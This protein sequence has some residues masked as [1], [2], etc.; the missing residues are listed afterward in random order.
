MRLALD[1]MG[2]DHAPKAMVEGGFDY[3]LAHP[4]QRVVLVGIREQV[5]AEIAATGKALRR[6]PPANLEVEHAP[7]VIGMA[8]KITA[9]RERPNDS[10]NRCAAL[11]KAGEADAVIYCGNTGCS[12]AA[13]Q[14]HFRCIPGIKRAGIISPLPTLQDPVWVLDTGFNSACKAENLVQFAQMGVVFLRHYAEKSNPRVGVLSNGAEEGKGDELATEA[15]SLLRQTTLNVVGNIEG[16]HIFEGVADVV[17]CDGFTGNVMLKTC[18]GAAWLLT[19]LIRREVN[20]SLV[21]KAGALVLKPSLRR[22]FRHVDW[23]YVGGVPLLGVN[24]ITIIGHGRS[25]RLAVFHAL[26]QAARCVSTGIIKHMVETF[27]QR[28]NGSGSGAAA[29]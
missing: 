29:G 4:D 17:V 9:V 5:A 23:N 7:E 27:S 13:A 24:G 11:L 18:E 8:D 16:N 1:A 3:A 21:A 12:G 10:I 15:L 25:S 22:M 6:D 28:T 2:G 14:L 20:H 26:R 19:S